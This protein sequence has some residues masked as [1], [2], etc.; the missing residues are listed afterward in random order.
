M[1]SHYYIFSA[2][3]SVQFLRQEIIGPDAYKPNCIQLFRERLLEK[4][5]TRQSRKVIWDMIDT[6]AIFLMT[7]AVEPTLVAFL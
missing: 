6:I 3:L 4:M 2:I 1:L 5:C 7:V